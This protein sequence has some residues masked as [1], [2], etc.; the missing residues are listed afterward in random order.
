MNCQKYQ[1]KRKIVK[2]F[3]RSKQRAALRKLFSLPHPTPHQIK[4]YYVFGIK[5]FLRRYIEIYRHLLSICFKNTVLGRQEM[6][7]NK[8]FSDTKQK[9]VCWK[10]VKSENF[11]PRCGSILFSMSSELRFVK[12]VRFFEQNCIV[13]C[14]IF[15]ASFCW[16]W[17]FLMEN[18]KLKK[19]ET[20]MISTGTFGLL[21]DISFLCPK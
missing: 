2:Y 6:V 12:W 8:Y 13:K 3:A 11:W 15:F 17:D 7:L 1:L 4:P 19:K 21:S 16:L 5:I 20:L 14:V 10:F 9:H 18:L